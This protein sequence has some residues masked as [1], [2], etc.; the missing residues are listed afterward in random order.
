MVTYTKKDRKFFRES[1]RIGGEK[2]AAALTP[3][4][5]KEKARQAAQAR[6]AKKKKNI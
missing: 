1:G 3:E 5:R 2:A 4:E 6:W